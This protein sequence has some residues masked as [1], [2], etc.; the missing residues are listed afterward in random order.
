MCDMSIETCKAILWK[1]GNQ[2]PCFARRRFQAGRERVVNN[3]HRV[4]VT[5]PC[6]TQFF[7]QL[8]SQRWRLKNIASCRGGVTRSQHFLATCNAPSGNCLQLFL[9]QL[10]ISCEQKTGSDCLIF[11]KL[12]S[13]FRWTC[14]T[15]DIS[16]FS[17]NSQRNILLPL[18]V[19]KLGC[20]TWNLSFNLSRNKKLGEKLPRVTCYTTLSPP[21]WN[22]LRAKH[23]PWLPNLHKITLQVSM[24]MS[25]TGYFYFSC[26]SQRNI[27]LPLQVA[28]L[29][30]YTWNL[31]CN[32]S[33][34]K[35]LQE[36][37]PRVT[38]PLRWLTTV[39][40]R[41]YCAR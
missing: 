41:H 9:R 20:Y 28:K 1:L 12:H 8:V 40:P 18:Q 29:G 21:V 38:W 2:S 15:K 30:C 24:D 32:L 36:K 13:R 4:C 10:E 7:L 25:H 11:T 35:K 37:L 33:R 14:H 5:P 22:L 6:N 17:C 19:A 26:N 31:S 34:S 39:F 3:F 16:T 27:L 23:G